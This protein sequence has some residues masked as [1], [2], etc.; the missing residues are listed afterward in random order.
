MKLFHLVVLR[1]IFLYFK[2]P[3]R[4][5]IPNLF[6]RFSNF[7]GLKHYILVPSNLINYQIFIIIYFQ[8]ILFH[9]FNP[10]NLIVNFKEFI[11]ICLFV[12]TFA[13][14]FF[15]VFKVN[16]DF[17]L[18]MKPNCPT[19]SIFPINLFT[20][21][22]YYPRNIRCVDQYIL[23]IIFFCFCQSNL[24]SGKYYLKVY[25]KVII[26]NFYIFNNSK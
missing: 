3:P 24:I 11:I 26:Y 19:P 1:F 14:F 8:F 15:I 7:H 5:F 4:V 18:I 10:I 25:N 20:I 9:L 13:R 23:T 16:H 21:T 2:A 22:R 6:S 12:R 17:D